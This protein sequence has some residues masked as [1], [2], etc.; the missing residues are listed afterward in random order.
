MYR[1][2]TN[3]LFYL[4]LVLTVV[5]SNPEINLLY[6][7]VTSCKG[8]PSNF[9]FFVERCITPIRSKVPGVCL[10]YPRIINQSQET[11]E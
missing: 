3:F 10:E 8:V 2:W 4:Q 5:S 9:T 1:V 7:I 6:T 11:T